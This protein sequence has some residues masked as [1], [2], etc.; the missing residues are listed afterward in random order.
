MLKLNFPVYKFRFKN[1]EN[2]IYIFDRIR[3]KFVV[4]TPEEW[5]RQHCVNFLIE[6]KGYPISY[7]NVEKQL[8]INDLTKRYDIVVFNKLKQI[9]I[10]ECKAPKVEITQNTFNQIAMYNTQ[11]KANFLMV[12]N[13]INHY[14][15]KIN[16]ENNGYIF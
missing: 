11:L 9:E 13:G 4:L 16:T 5:V 6:D 2:T 8:T 12:T 7:I 3:K 1:K 14:N 15:C 10:L